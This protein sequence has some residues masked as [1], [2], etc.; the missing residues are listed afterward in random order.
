VRH[1]VWG[2]PLACAVAEAVFDIINTTE[3]LDGVKARNR[4]F[5]EGLKKMNATRKLF[6][7][8]RGEGVWLGCELVEAYR[9]RAM[10]F[11]RAGHDAGLL[12]LVAGPDVI[13]LAPALTI[14][15]DDIIEGLGRL[16][17]ALQ[18]RRPGVTSPQCSPCA[19]RRR[20]TCPRFSPCRCAPAPD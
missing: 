12:M 9:G 8:I 14:S 4:L 11:V 6:A 16:D 3:V 7:D 20:P 19:R 18:S 13:R 1:D 17:Q 2:N 10:E 15:L 5:L